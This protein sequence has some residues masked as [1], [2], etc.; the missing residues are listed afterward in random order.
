MSIFI[1]LSHHPAE[2]DYQP[3]T[4]SVEEG[5]IVVNLHS[6]DLRCWVGKDTLVV[7]LPY[8]IIVHVSPGFF[9]FLLCLSLFVF[10]PLLPYLFSPV[11]SSPPP[12]SPLCILISSSFDVPHLQTT[13]LLLLS[14]SV[15]SPATVLWV[16]NSHRNTSPREV[17]HPVSV[18]HHGKRWWEEKD[19]GKVCLTSQWI[20]EYKSDVNIRQWPR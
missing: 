14:C 6:Q 8:L 12:F 19:R 7:T 5:F 4:L 11:P 9:C 13:L 15:K 1:Y 10:P 18:G 3:T 2:T 20:I 17:C 16:G